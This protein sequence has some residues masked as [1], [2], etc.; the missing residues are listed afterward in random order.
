MVHFLRGELVIN[1]F[2]DSLTG[3]QMTVPVWPPLPCCSYTVKSNFCGAE[4]FFTL[5]VPFVLLELRGACTCAVRFL[6]SAS[7]G[8]FHPLIYTIA[9]VLKYT[10][11]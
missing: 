1:K 8:S 4:R 3:L 11:N 10:S 2:I 5:F 6:L 9:R 7:L